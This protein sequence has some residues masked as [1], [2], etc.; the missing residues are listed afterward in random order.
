MAAKRNPAETAQ[1]IDIK[2]LFR[3]DA[4]PRKTAVQALGCALEADGA[5]V[6]AGL[7]DG[8]DRERRAIALLD[9]FEL[10]EADKFGL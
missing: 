2:P 6:A 10:S 3:D 1:I 5:F 7:P 9:F 4:A 8:W